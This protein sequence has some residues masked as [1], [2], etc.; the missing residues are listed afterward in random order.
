MTAATQVD[1]RD[2]WMQILYER[3]KLEIAQDRH[4]ALLASLDRYAASLGKTPEELLHHAKHRLLS[5][6]Q[7]ALIVHYATNHETRFYRNPNVVDLV[8]EYAR[9]NTRCR[10]LS[11]GCS[12]GEEPYTFA[13]ELIQQTL[14]N[15]HIHATDVSQLCVEIG[16]AGKYKDSP[17]IPDRFVYR[18]AA[19]HMT[20][21]QWVRSLVT[22][23]QHNILSD[24]PIDFRNPNI[25]VT[26]NMLIYYRRDTRHRIL[27]N[28]SL[29]LQPG[30]YLICGPTEEASWKPKDM[31]RMPVTAA[32]VFR[33][34]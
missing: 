22:F 20:F 4:S 3:F 7:W 11:V 26:Q 31:E 30:G 9:E 12:T 15:F 17:I 6:S 33:K 5:S 24:R 14:P 34:A 10:I 13:I 21:Y 16:E 1:Q 2:S 23:E 8:N 29:M 27:E 25:I 28:L 32:T 19:G 18:D